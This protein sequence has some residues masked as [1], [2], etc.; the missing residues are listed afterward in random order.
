V[1]YPRDL[2][3]AAIELYR[4]QPGNQATLRRSVSTAYYA[5]FH[6][7]IETAC[8]NWPAS[9]RS[10]VARQFEHRRIKAASSDAAKKGYTSVSPVQAGLV[11]VVNTFV[12][13][14]ESRLVADYDLGVVLSPEEAALDILL[15]EEAF[16]I[17]NEIKNDP[18]AQD[19][20]FSLLFKDRLQPASE[21]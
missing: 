7:I 21:R 20:L 2:L 10:R 17:W 3:D 8:E 13:L 14:Q 12:Q 16:K 1:S 9:Q 15:V 19:Y 4:V 18:I 5:L 11:V 6:L